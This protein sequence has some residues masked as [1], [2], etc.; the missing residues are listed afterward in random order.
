MIGP[1]RRA[2]VFA[3][4][5]RN[6]ALVAVLAV[7]ALFAVTWTTM[8]AQMRRALEAE[9]AT[10]LAGLVD[11]YASGGRAELLVRLAD[12]YAVK[13]PQGRRAHYLVAT[14]AGEPIAGDVQEW[15][16]LGA[17]LSERE[18]IT[19]P[20]GS[21]VFA[22]AARLDGDLDLLVA[23]EYSADRAAM[24]RTAAVFLGAGGFLI[25]AVWL[26]ARR[27]AQRLAR[28]VQRINAAFGKSAFYEV[29][30]RP[31]EIDELADHGARSIARM[32]SLAASHKAISDNVAHEIRTPL[33]HLDQRMVQALQ[34]APEPEGGPLTQARSEIRGIVSLL[35][36][37]LDI[38][39]NEARRGE[40][41]GLEPVDLTALLTRIAELY[42]GSF[43]DA[44]LA[45]DTVLAPGVEIE[46]ESMQLSRMVSNLL[47]NAIKYVPRGGNVT[48]E[49]E[50]GPRILVRD[51]GPGVLPAKRTAVFE[52]F[53]RAERADTAGHGLGLALARAIAER[54]GLI[55]RLAE[56]GAGATFVAEPA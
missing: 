49:L 17:A 8:E 37:L 25:L 43:E 48:L 35:D 15:P 38:A 33:L 9:T 6:A 19:L 5:A 56:E 23:R 12:R 29:Q 16:A 50:P 47:D 27:T 54:H 40:R 26:A 24:R 36:S 52:R 42:E 53:E 4:L 31:D 41:A 45:F 21:P 2:S 11:I 34:R 44:G 18:F 32:A 7:L 55:L 28:R 39:S 51:D 20:G 13:G 46:G 1:F 10:D 22:R 30:D 3:R 14:T